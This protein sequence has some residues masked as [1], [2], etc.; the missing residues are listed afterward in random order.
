MPGEHICT[1]ASD[2]SVCASR[3]TIAWSEHMRALPLNDFIYIVCVLCKYQYLAK[4]WR[5]HGRTLALC[6]RHLKVV[7]QP[8]PLAG[9]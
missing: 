5:R 1:A 9:A 3:V 4:F 8:P 2:M 7:A 6:L